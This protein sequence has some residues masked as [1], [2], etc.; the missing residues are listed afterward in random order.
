MIIVIYLDKLC[1]TVAATAMVPEPQ[2][3][4]IGSICFYGAEVLYLESSKL[5]T[6]ISPA[7]VESAFV[8]RE[9]RKCGRLML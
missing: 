5:I 8:K 9:M 4:G 2:H 7:G 6:R 3:A 1:F